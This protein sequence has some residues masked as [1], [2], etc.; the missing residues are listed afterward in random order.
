[1]F[2]LRENSLWEK[3]EVENNK[4]PRVSN[5]KINLGHGSRTDHIRSMEFMSTSNIDHFSER[6]SRTRKNTQRAKPWIHEV[7][8]VETQC[9]PTSS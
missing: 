8:H 6:K 9:A 3:R 5:P 4:K 7:R 2:K 1:M